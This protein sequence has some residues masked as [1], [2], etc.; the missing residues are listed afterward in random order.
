M[1]DDIANRP[2]KDAF[3]QLSFHFFR[4][5][6]TPLTQPAQHGIIRVQIP[7]MFARRTRDKAVHHP[8][9]MGHGIHL[10]R[11]RTLI[12]DQNLASAHPGWHFQNDQIIIGV[13]TFV[14]DC[15]VKIVGW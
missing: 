8:F 14:A 13:A 12:A 9:F 4:L 5:Q 3:S 7:E 15:L 10:E 2:V 6:E 1:D 11:D